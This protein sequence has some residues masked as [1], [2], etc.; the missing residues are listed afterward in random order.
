MASRSSRL[1]P[2]LTFASFS[3][4]LDIRLAANPKEDFFRLEANF[5]L[6]RG[7]CNILPVTE[8]VTLGV[9][10]YTT[11]IAP[12]AF[13]PVPK[14]R[15]EEFVFKGTIGGVWL[16]VSIESEGSN[17][18]ELHARARGADLKGIANPVPVTLGFSDD[19]ITAQVNS[20]ERG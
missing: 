8:A 7:S 12:G 1:S 6:A 2:G 5:T 17:S 15:S 14:E 16:E 18:Y 20:G 3:A 9:G 13:K 11:V 4:G 19:S 10:P